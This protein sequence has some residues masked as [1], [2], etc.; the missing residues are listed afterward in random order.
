M[1]EGIFSF[2]YDIQ[3]DVQVTQMPGHGL[4]LSVDGGHCNIG[5]DKLVCRFVS[6]L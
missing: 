2:V 5:A 3:N 4:N 6:M 1:F